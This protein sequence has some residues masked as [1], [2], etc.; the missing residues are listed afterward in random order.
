MGVLEVEFLR[1]CG[2]IGRVHSCSLWWW[3]LCNLEIAPSPYR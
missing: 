3:G 2:K 1:F